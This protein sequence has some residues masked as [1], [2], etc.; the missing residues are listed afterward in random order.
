MNEQKTRWQ[1]PLV[2]SLLYWAMFAALAV[3]TLIFTD[4]T[5]DNAGISL[6]KSLHS[7]WLTAIMQ[8]ASFVGEEIVMVPVGLLIVI[9]GL[10][11]RQRAEVLLFVAAMAGGQLIKDVLKEL[12]ARPR[13]AGYSLVELP[14]SYSFP[15]GHAMLSCVFFGIICYLA[16]RFLP[17]SPGRRLLAF[18]SALSAFAISF[19]RIYLG[20]HYATDVL[21]G[22]SI[23]LAWVYLL[24]FVYERWID[25]NLQKRPTVKM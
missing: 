3:Y 4:Q 6:A 25:R 14:T 15:S 11:Y 18:A 12:V 5:I 2:L 8:A 9:I 22:I 19:S 23:G 7:E 24:A 16:Y 13:P 17:K 21:A 10:Y 20:V 1:K